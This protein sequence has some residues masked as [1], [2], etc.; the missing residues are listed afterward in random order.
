MLQK[1]GASSQVWEQRGRKKFF[2]LINILSQKLELNTHL[3]TV[4]KK[5]F[6]YVRNNMQPVYIT[7]WSL[8]M[9]G[10]YPT[11]SMDWTGL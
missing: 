4:E 10:L 7:N 9:T 8:H 1:A 2:Q 5:Y 11:Q 3:K 6:K